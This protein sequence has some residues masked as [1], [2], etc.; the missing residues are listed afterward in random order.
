MSSHHK[1]TGY[2]QINKEYFDF[3]WVIREFLLILANEPA[4]LCSPIFQVGSDD[5]SLQLRFKKIKKLAVEQFVCLYIDLDGI[6]K[7][8][9][10]EISVIKDDKI[11]YT[12]VDFFDDELI[13]IRT[14]QVFQMNRNDISQFISSTGTV[15]IRCEL[16]LA[17]GSTEHLLD[18]ES[19]DANE[20]PKLKFDWIFLNENLTDVK[21]RTASGKEVPAH[22]L[23]L[24]AASPVFRAMFTHDMLE[25][26]SQSVD[27]IDISYDATV[28][29]LRYIYTGAV[30]T[31]DCSLTAEILAAA[32]KYQLKELKDRC[33]R[34][35]GSNLSTEN[36]I[37]V[38]KVADKY[39]MKNLKRKAVDFFKHKVNESS[40][41]DKVGTM[42][43]RM[44][45]FLSK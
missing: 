13:G 21:L 18:N 14:K 16:K 32:E 4:S 7:T 5:A 30:E 17:T 24:A 9:S 20:V 35:L 26:K 31:Q 43:I 45:D 23:M 27:M 44:A 28:E 25:N 3:T 15:I 37:D 2:S 19:R 6:D 38:L 42:I 8:F 33:E 1:I 10:Y 36:A 29:M 41:S 22:R 40:D 34:I 39:S 12:L 11:I